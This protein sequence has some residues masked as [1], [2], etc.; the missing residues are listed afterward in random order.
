MVLVN[1]APIGWCRLQPRRLVFTD[2]D[3]S[4][5]SYD[6]RVGDSAY[7]ARLLRLLGFLIIPVTAK[8]V[9]EVVALR[10]RLGLE[11]DPFIAVVEAGGAVYASPGFLTR[12]TGYDHV[13]GLEY[14]EVGEPL[15]RLEPLLEEIASTP[16]SRPL[17]R[18][19]K[20]PPRIAERMTGLEGFQAELARRRRFI[21]VY[22]S[23]SRSC[24]E[25][26]AQRAVELG[27]TVR[28]GRLLHVGKGYGKAQAVELLLEEPLLHGAPTVG[29]G[30]TQL[31]EDLLESVG[32]AVIIPQTDGRLLAR[33]R[34]ADYYVAPEPAPEGWVHVARLLALGSL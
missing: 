1:K 11:G 5:V 23:P 2:I 32:T 33:P 15:E 18:L 4:M 22:W 17:Y 25:R 14:I 3:G 9:E 16:C 13:L 28:Y 6:G 19:T 26:A 24:M 21:E 20:A 27:L 34:R 7:Y 31:D 12:P 10:N 30:D 8:T 29:V